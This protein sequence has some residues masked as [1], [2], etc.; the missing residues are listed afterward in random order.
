M[1]D[2]NINYKDLAEYM[3][4]AINQY[5]HYNRVD[6]GGYSFEDLINWLEHF[7]YCNTDESRIKELNRS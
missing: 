2:K 3:R 5:E 4:L 7:G 6:I 1:I